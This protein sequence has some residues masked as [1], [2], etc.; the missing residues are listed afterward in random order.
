MTSHFTDGH[1]KVEE[2]CLTLVPALEGLIVGLKSFLSMTEV[3]LLVPTWSLQGMGLP[4]W[5]K[6]GEESLEGVCIQQSNYRAPDGCR[7]GTV[8]GEAETLL[9]QTL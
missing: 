6:S 8:P 5:R 4:R 1:V 2:T 9:S 3:F 7:P